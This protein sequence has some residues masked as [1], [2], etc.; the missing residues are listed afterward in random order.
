MMFC[1]FGNTDVRVETKTQRF[2]TSTHTTRSL[3]SNVARSSSAD[4]N[5]EDDE[6]KI[7]EDALRRLRPDFECR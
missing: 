6:D 5:E 7:E 4:Y 1:A 2:D 3:D